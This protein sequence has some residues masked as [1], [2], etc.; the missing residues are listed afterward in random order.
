MRL[1]DA[2]RGAFGPFAPKK[3]KP[4][5]KKVGPA[6]K[7]VGAVPLLTGE[8]L[9]YHHRVLSVFAFDWKEI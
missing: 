7:K 9:C 8:R 6:P 5:P 4:A 1:R 3:V 2:R